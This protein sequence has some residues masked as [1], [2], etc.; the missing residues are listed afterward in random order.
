[1]YGS[2]PW[3]YRSLLMKRGQLVT[4]THYTRTTDEAGKVSKGENTQPLYGARASD[5]EDHLADSDVKEGD[6]VWLL[7]AA[8]DTL[9]VSERDKVTDS[10][11]LIYSI[12]KVQ[13]VQPGTVKIATRVWLRGGNSA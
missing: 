4:H 6:E 2:E 5:V 13:K 11:G 1:M 9:G 3:I 12:I 7:E 10:Q 8:S